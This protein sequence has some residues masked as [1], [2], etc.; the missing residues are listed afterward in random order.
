MAC[1]RNRVAMLATNYAECY[2]L[3]AACST[4]G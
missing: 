1:K 4:F 2:N 3:F